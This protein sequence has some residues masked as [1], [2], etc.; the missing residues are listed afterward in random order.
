MPFDEPVGSLD[1]WQAGTYFSDIGLHQAVRRVV[2]DNCAKTLTTGQKSLFG[3]LFGK[4]KVTS[5]VKRLTQVVTFCEC[6]APFC[7]LTKPIGNVTATVGIRRRSMKQPFQGG[8][9]CVFSSL[10]FS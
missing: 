6:S 4:V 1:H 8:V 7:D 10:W 5:A 3:T 9:E 2:I